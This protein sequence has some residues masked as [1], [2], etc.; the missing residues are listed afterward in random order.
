MSKKIIVTD[1]DICPWSFRVESE[2]YTH[3]CNNAQ[4]YITKEEM[5]NIPE[6]CPL[7]DETPDNWV[8][9]EDRLPENGQYVYTYP[10]YTSSVYPDEPRH[11]LKFSNKYGP[12]WFYYMGESEHKACGSE[13]IITHWQPLPAP[14]KGV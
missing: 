6:W 9:V 2:N 4:M 8:S 10:T 5:Q 12:E 11:V 13:F 14:P 3:F 1:C 7:E